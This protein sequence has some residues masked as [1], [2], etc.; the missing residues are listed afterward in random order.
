MGGYGVEGGNTVDGGF[1]LFDTWVT[2]NP[3]VDLGVWRRI[4]R[5]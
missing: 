3:S 1:L 4:S 5:L 2:L